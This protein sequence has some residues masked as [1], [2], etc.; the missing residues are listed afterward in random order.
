MARRTTSE[1]TE[2]F[3][4]GDGEAVSSPAPRRRRRVTAASAAPA[5]APV[6]EQP[7]S[8]ERSETV[9]TSGLEEP[10][11]QQAPAAPA[12]EPVPPRR[13]RKVVAA[14]AAPEEVSRE[15]ASS[16]LSSSAACDSSSASARVGSSPRERERRSRSRPRPTRP[17]TRRPSPT[18]T[19][20]PPA[21]ASMRRRTSRSPGFL[22]PRSCSRPPTPAGP[23][24]VV[25][26][27]RRAPL[28]RRRRLP[29]VTR[30]PRTRRM[31]GALTRGP[32]SRGMTR[33]LSPSPPVPTAVVVAAVG[34]GGLPPVPG[35]RRSPARTLPLTRPTPRSQRPM[36]LTVLTGPTRPGP[37]LRRTPTRAGPAASGA[38]AGAV[39]ARA[40][41]AKTRRAPTPMMSRRPRRMTA[42]MRLPRARPPPMPSRRPPRVP[43]PDR[44]AGDVAPV[45]ARTVVTCVTR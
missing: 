31:R 34:V 10:G 44:A 9:T 15:G 23:V 19:T 6:A 33:M 17:T 18:R 4:H 12:A 29:R 22:P 35:P 16:A 3:E 11:V 13:R 20:S 1:S 2:S 45:P 39:G 42:P 7:G 25:G 37:I 21:R 36:A 41:V 30:E 28:P 5:Q 24:G 38:V 27:P 32:V 26:S 40:R 43:C 8:A 14:S